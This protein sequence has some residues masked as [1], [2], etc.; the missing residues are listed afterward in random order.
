[1]VYKVGLLIREDSK[2]FCVIKY[3]IFVKKKQNK[4]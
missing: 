1:M 4:T 2:I 3:Y